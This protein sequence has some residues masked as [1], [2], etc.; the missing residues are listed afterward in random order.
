[1]YVFALSGITEGGNLEHVPVPMCAGTYVE[2]LPRTELSGADSNTTVILL[3]VANS[4]YGT[5]ISNV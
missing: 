3:H 2:L 4:L 5:P 1:M